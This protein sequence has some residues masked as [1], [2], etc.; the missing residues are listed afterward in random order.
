MD[1]L[2]PCSHP[3]YNRNMARLS[4][5]Y[6]LQQAD[7]ALLEDRARIEEIE[8]ILSGDETVQRA[9]E[10]LEAAQERL[11]SA[12]SS[13]G[14]A[15]KSVTFQT[16][17]L[18]KTEK[19]LYGGSVQ[20]PKELE[21]LQ[22][23]SDS[24]KRH[25]VTLEDRLLEAMIQLERAETEYEDAKSDLVEAQAE[26]EARN[27]DLGKE[28]GE[29]IAH[30]ERVEAEREAA[31]ANVDPESLATYHNVRS[32]AGRFP[33][34]VVE[35]GACGVCGLA[36]SASKLQTVRAGDEIARCRQCGRILYAG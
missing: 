30:I 34:A 20:N 19:A 11:V 21:E 28:K 33:V 7:E 3:L 4:N 15:D 26:T 6:R 29:L 5:L 27:D 1:C 31:L 24:L 16:E 35:G 18:D 13:A 12:R 8:E 17:K 10:S 2:L 22:M 25:M 9:A 14:E 32:K 36:I 23:E